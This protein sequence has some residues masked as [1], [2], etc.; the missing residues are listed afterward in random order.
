MENFLKYFQ[1]FNPC[2]FVIIWFIFV[3]CKIIPFFVSIKFADRKI[4]LF[5]YIET[6]GRILDYKESKQV[7]KQKNPETG[8]I[9]NKEIINLLPIIEYSVN[10]KTYQYEYRTAFQYDL[11][12]KRIGDTV[13][14]YYDAKEPKFAKA[15]YTDIYNVEIN[16]AKKNTIGIFI[17]ITIIIVICIILSVIGR[18]K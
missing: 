17:I 2:F 16:N 13:K 18:L 1:I 4:S 5:G 9:E 7:V 6:E 8:L 3:L 10:D 11:K 12:A 15:K 14:L